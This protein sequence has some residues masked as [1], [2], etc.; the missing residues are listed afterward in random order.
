MTH[1]LFAAVLLGLVPSSFAV[2]Q[3]PRATLTTADVPVTKVVLFSS[4]V[5]Y[6]EHAGTVHGTLEK[7]FGCYLLIVGSPDRIAFRFQS[8]LD[9]SYAVGRVYFHTPEQYAC[10]AR[11]VVAAETAPPAIAAPF[12][13]VLFGVRNDDDL[14]TQL[15]TNQLVEPLARE[16]TEP[17]WTIETVPSY[18]LETYA[19]P[20]RSKITPFG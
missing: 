7:A 3:T 4:G 2:A 11:T 16:I 14:S 6:F 8:Q 15:S 18:S 19:R 1:R 12:R 20:W 13:A 9:V 17:G 5:G 10:Y